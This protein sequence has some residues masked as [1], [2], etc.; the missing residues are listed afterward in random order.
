MVQYELAR[1]RVE[2]GERLMQRAPRPFLIR[3]ENSE[4]SVLSTLVMAQ[5]LPQMTTGGSAPRRDSALRDAAHD[6]ARRIAG[7]GDGEA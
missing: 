2:V 7:D 6:A 3:G 1:R 4:N 5:L